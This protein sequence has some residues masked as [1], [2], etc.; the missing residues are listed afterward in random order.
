MKYLIR[1]F[2]RSC[3]H[4]LGLDLARYVPLS[5][6][7]SANAITT[8]FDIGANQGQFGRELRRDGY[9]GRIISFEPMSAAHAVLLGKSRGDSLWSVHER[10]AIGAEDKTI[11]INVSKNSG[12]SSILPI[13][14][15][16]TDAA[17]DSVYV[18]KES[19]QQVRFDRIFRNYVGPAERFFMKI[20][21]QGYEREVMAG[22]PEALQLV[23]GLQLEISFFELYESQPGYKYFLQ[24]AEANGFFLWSIHDGFSNLAVSKT[25][26]AD[27][28]FF[29]A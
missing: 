21:T 18:G 29:R 16:H 23:T 5:R 26:Q 17:P 10:C 19:V 24:W 2:V 22:A 25:L 28:C 1:S 20:D 12:S 11:S 13:L 27:I 7:L 8:V 4:R 15:E 6:A 9:R 3:A 14:A